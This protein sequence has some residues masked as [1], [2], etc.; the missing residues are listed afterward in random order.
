MNCKVQSYVSFLQRT[1]R[2]KNIAVL[3][4]QTLRGVHVASGEGEGGINGGPLIP[5][6][7]HTKLHVTKHLLKL[8]HVLLTGMKM[9]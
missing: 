6:K 2:I 9:I 1:I 5:L 4:K 8:K 3:S 7:Q